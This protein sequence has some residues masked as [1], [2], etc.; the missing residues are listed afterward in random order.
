MFEQDG[1]VPDFQEAISP[2]IVHDLDNSA[3][4]SHNNDG[5]PN[6]N[7][8][9]LGDLL[10][11]PTTPSG[12]AGGNEA[13][14]APRRESEV[15]R[16]AIALL[17]MCLERRPSMA[18]IDRLDSIAEWA[19][20][21]A[22]DRHNLGGVQQPPPPPTLSSRADGQGGNREGFVDM[23][24][25]LPGISEVASLSPSLVKAE[26]PPPPYDPVGS[27]PGATA[28]PIKK[29]GAGAAG[30]RKR[31]ASPRP[32]P[33]PSPVSLVSPHQSPTF[34]FAEDGDERKP[35]PASP[36]LDTA[37]L[38]PADHR[39]ARGRGRSMQLKAMTREQ[40]EAEAEAR[41]EKNRQAA[42]DCRLRR[43][44]QVGLLTEQVQTLRRKDSQS[45]ATI[46]GLRN[47]VQQ[48][49]ATLAKRM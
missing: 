10:A 22:P 27:S 3:I 17:A 13:P 39:P 42:R 23:E 31:T 5:I 48:L 9:D 26:M 33:Q 4:F 45:Q 1:L 25:D 28:A 7:G 19:E 41:L 16:D 21:A 32:Q 46:A 30:K 35:R 36:D 15:D 34:A 14:P 8:L 38:L 11:K 2:D 29:V 47:E 12:N 44:Q 6:K 37:G 24:W 49:R 20:P 43:K 40:I 18:D